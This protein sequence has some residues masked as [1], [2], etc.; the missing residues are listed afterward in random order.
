MWLVCALLNGLR[1]HT[2][3]TTLPINREF[4]GASTGLSDNSKG[5]NIWEHS[6]G[7]AVPLMNQ[8]I[9]NQCKC[10]AGHSPRMLPNSITASMGTL[11]TQ[12]KTAV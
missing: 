5:K 9:D 4:N 8:L 12:E 7:H 2:V 3:A 6:F 10:G 11:P 1:F